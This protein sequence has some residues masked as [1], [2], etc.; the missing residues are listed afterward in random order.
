MSDKLDA[1]QVAW[2]SLSATKLGTPKV[3]FTK[4]VKSEIQ[5]DLT[6][7][8]DEFRTKNIEC[9]EY[10]LF[11]ENYLHIIYIYIYIYICLKQNKSSDEEILL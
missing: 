2:I 4:I 9:L 7:M 6:K 5:E 1:R 10:R 3:T 8:V 11:L